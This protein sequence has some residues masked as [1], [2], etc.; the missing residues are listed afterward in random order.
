MSLATSSSSFVDLNKIQIQQYENLLK[1]GG[2]AQT[3]SVRLVSDPTCLILLVEEIFFNNNNKNKN[4]TITTSSRILSNLFQA[5]S[6]VMIESKDSCVVDLISKSSASFFFSCSS[7][8]NIP[9]IESLFSSSQKSRLTF[10][11]KIVMRK[12]NSKFTFN[13]QQ[14]D[15]E[16]ENPNDDKK[17]ID[18]GEPS[19]NFFNETFSTN[20]NT[21][22][23]EL[24]SF[25]WYIA[26][27]LFTSAFVLTEEQF[28]VSRSH[29]QPFDAWQQVPSEL[30]DATIG[31]KHRNE[32]MLLIARQ[33]SQSFKSEK[34]KNTKIRTKSQKNQKNLEEEEEEDKFLKEYFETS[35]EA[36]L[37]PDQNDK[38]F[39]KNNNEKNENNEQDLVNKMIQEQLQMSGYYDGVKEEEVQKH[40]IDEIFG[41]SNE[42]HQDEQSEATP[43]SSLSSPSASFD[44]EFEQIVHD[45]G[46]IDVD[47]E[48]TMMG[49]SSTDEEIEKLFDEM[50]NEL[51]GDHLHDQNMNDEE[52]NVDEFSTEN[53]KQKSSSSSRRRSSALY[54]ISY[55]HMYELLA[56]LLSPASSSSTASSL[57]PRQGS[58]SLATF[59]TWMKFT[60]SIDK[61][62]SLRH[63][64]TAVG[65][66]LPK[67]MMRED[68]D[69]VTVELKKKAA[70]YIY[71][72]FGGRNAGAGN[73]AQQHH[74]FTSFSQRILREMIF[75]KVIE[76]ADAVYASSVASGLIEKILMNN[77][78][79]KNGDGNENDDDEVRAEDI[80]RF[81]SSYSFALRILEMRQ[82]MFF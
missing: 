34:K 23:E 20:S 26:D 24:H 28:Y 19:F 40:D 64:K 18:F 81:D 48:E 6:N 56:R 2:F 33:A 67:M 78:N 30:L 47:Q 5:I 3:Q 12:M 75:E 14:L 68:E 35:G 58:T 1:C 69:V 72:E 62:T 25:L 52:E 9:F 42:V 66:V 36:T 82:Q 45:Y 21:K 80:F 53:E 74:L 55:P 16:F 50:E 61:E 77:N 10:F 59:L 71:V 32:K 27:S 22:N 17:E 76:G 44:D 4:S 65:K 7:L 29:L 38:A 46:E 43:P 70:K 63:L 8:R 11:T 73:S 31:R 54:S 37:N 41:R 15:D 39:S 13:H 57:S 60:K 49:M 51:V 79:N